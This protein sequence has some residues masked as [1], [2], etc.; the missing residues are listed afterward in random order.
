MDYFLNLV[1]EHKFAYIVIISI[2]ATIL[3]L[4]NAIEF[5]ERIINHRLLLVLS[6]AVFYVLVW[7]SIKTESKRKWRR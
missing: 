3:I 2:V 7:L 1:R 6:L 5:A 4:N